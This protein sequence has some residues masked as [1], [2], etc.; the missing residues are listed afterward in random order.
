MS[1]KATPDSSDEYCGTSYAAKLLNLSVGSVQALVEKNE[2]QAW[3]TQGGHRRISIQSIFDYQNRSSSSPTVG[4]QEG[5]YLKVL[6]VED[7]P[8]TRA[9]Y[10]AHFDKW[11]LAIDATISGS[12]IE[13]LLDLPVIK[14]QVLLAD[15]RMPGIDGVE[16]LRQLHGHPQ[17]AQV[18]VI[19]ITGLND[20]EIAELG[21]LPDGTQVLRKPVDMGWLRGYFQ[22]MLTIRLGPKRRGVS[23]VP[24]EPTPPTANTAAAPG[25]A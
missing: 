24:T 19:V 12:A 1:H 6:V 21:D 2:L 11:D 25:P 14:P 7:D 15:L 18:A 3:K 22:A 20:D 17:F 5:K 4:L 8:S 23:A 16:M 13:A 10:R 9:M